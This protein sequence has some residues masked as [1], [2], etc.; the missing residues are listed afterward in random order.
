[1]FRSSLKTV[2]KKMPKIKISLVED[3]ANFSASLKD[4]IKTSEQMVFHAH[5]D[6]A[7]ACLESLQK[8]GLDETDVLLLDLNLPGRGGLSLVPVLQNRLPEMRI[9]V[10]TQDSD[11]HTALEAIRLGVSGYLLKDARVADIR[12]G[13]METMDGG[14]LIDPQLSKLILHAL[15]REHDS[16]DDESLSKREEEVLKLMSMGYVKKEVAAQLGLSERTV[17]YYTERIYKKLQ[18]PNITAAVASA[19]RKGLI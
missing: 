4:L 7:E 16:D 19:I 1:M 9:L 13:I 18:V 5:Y 2:K 14:C 8:G 10:L 12:R 3:N 11:Y 15:D 6:C 17:A